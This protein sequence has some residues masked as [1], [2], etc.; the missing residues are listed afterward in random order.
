MVQIVPRTP[1]FRGGVTYPTARVGGG[2]Q[3]A[4]FKPH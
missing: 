3:S 2:V 1:F 4:Y